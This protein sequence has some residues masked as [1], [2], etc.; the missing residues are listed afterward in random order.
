MTSTL[1][2]SVLFALAFSL[3]TC[4]DPWFQG[5][6]GNRTKS[7][8]LLSVALGD[9]RRLFAKHFYVKADAYF[10]SGYYP[11][12]YD[13]KPASAEMHMAAGAQRHEPGAGEGHEAHEEHGEHGEHD[14]ENADFLGKPK[15][16]IDAFNRHFYPSRHRHLDDEQAVARREHG[17]N[18]SKAEGGENLERELLPWLRLA[19]DLDPQRTETYVVASHWM[20]TRLGKV[21]EAEQ[22]LREGLQANPEEAELFFELGKVYFENRHDVTRARNVWELALKKWQQRESVKAE[23]NIFLYAQI[24]G[25]LAKLEEQ[26]QRYAKAIEYL[27]QLKLISPSKESL[28]KWVD[29]L[30]KKAS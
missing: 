27:E 3:A 20:R 7:A 23:P 29:T 11:S 18:G 25:S 16:W 14:E 8:N 15:D 10:H 1:T 28:Q 12:I 22:F 17:S 6:A 21:A 2:L 26:E 19:A 5:W 24:L 4:L 13:T 30:R 9:S